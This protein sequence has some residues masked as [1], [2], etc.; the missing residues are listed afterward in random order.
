MVAHARHGHKL[1]LSSGLS[2][3]DRMLVITLLE[4]SEGE[5]DVVALH[6][7]IGPL[8]TCSGLEPVLIYKPSTY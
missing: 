6:Q 7:P 1:Q 5:E 4:V 3:S 8:E 2:V